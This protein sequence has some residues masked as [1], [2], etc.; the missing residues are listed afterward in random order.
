M[1]SP[2][3]NCALQ[4]GI[5]WKQDEND[6]KITDEQ[7]FYELVFGS[8]DCEHVKTASETRSDELGVSDLSRYTWRLIW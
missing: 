3:R 8:V 2:L 5:D 4:Y 1:F 6:C 7:K